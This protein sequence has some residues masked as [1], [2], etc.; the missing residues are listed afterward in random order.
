MTRRADNPIKWLNWLSSNAE[1]SDFPNLTSITTNRIPTPDGRRN[2]EFGIGL[3]YE[4]TLFQTMTHSWSDVDWLPYNE[5]KALTRAQ[6]DYKVP[7]PSPLS[8]PYDITQLHYDAIPSTYYPLNSS[9]SSSFNTTLDTLPDPHTLT[10]H[11][12]PL[13]TNFYSSQ[14]PSLIHCN[15]VD[16]KMHLGPVWRKMWYQPFARALLRGFMRSIQTPSPT[17]AD[18]SEWS[19]SSVLGGVRTDKGDPKSWADLCW[20][21]E[22][23][24]FDDGMGIWEWDDEKNA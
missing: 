3:D 24:I 22:E 14:I 6:A 9:S 17:N 5:P 21:Y 16:S 11:T 13:A 15:G 12:V 8:L 2:Y 20:G 23:D 7:H 1:T 19:Q 10:W 4:S 18:T